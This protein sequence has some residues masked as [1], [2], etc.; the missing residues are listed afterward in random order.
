MTEIEKRILTAS[1]LITVIVTTVRLGPY[2]F[3]ALL[4]L[5]NLLSLDEFY[6]LVEKTGPPP[7]RVVGAFVSTTMIFS[8]MATLTN[9]V[10]WKCLLLNIPVVFCTFIDALYRPVYEPFQRLAI[11]FLG[12]G[13][14]S[15][16]I[17]C[18]AALSFQAPFSPNYQFEIPLGVFL[19]LWMNDSSAYVTGRCFGTHPL[20]QRISPGKTW[21]GSVG[22]AVAALVTGY[23]LSRY[24]TFLSLIEWECLSMIIVVTGTYGD[25]IKSLLK[26]N[27]GVKDSGNILPGHGGMLDRFD[28]LL[29]SAPFVYTYLVLLTK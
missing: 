5:I 22:G 14:I 7:S 28:S 2:S 27:L 21:E 4:L 6:R 13:I 10:S 9:L 16:P 3:A 15:L 11:T 1:V 25:L 12:V 18:F 19:L 17:C 8:V 26:R 20:F 24:F 29:G 23:L